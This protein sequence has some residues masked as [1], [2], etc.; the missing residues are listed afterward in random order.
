MLGS[1]SNPRVKDPFALQRI[2][3]AGDPTIDSMPVYLKGTIPI[4]SLDPSIAIYDVFRISTDDYAD[5]A[6]K[7]D[8]IQLYARVFD[9][10]GNFVTNMADPYKK[11]P[12]ETYFTY[13]EEKLGKHYRQRVEE[14]PEFTVREFGAGDSIAYSL[15]LTVDYSGSME[16]IKETIAEG[17]ELMADMKFPYD[18][19]SMSTFN[20]EYDQK[21]PFMVNS[22]SI[23]SLFRT[24]KYRNFGLFSAVRDAVANSVDSLSMTPSEDPRVLVVFSDGDD[25]YSTAKI[26]DIIEK[27]KKENINIFTIAFG[28]SE[29]ENLRYMAEYTGGK[30]YK[31]RSKEELLAIFKDIYMSLRYYYL[32]TYV[33][34]VFWGYHQVRTDLALKGRSDLLSGYAEYDTSEL[35]PWDDPNNTFERPIEF[36]FNK[37]DLKPESQPIIDEIVDAMMSRPIMRIEVRGHT[38]NVG[39]PEYN[40]DLSERRAAVVKNAIIEAGINQRRVRSRGFGYSMPLETNDTEEGRARN[41][42]TEFMV[43]AK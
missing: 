15:S 2:A 1:C 24:V 6:D 27:A 7:P 42:R 23:I 32:I 5:K 35:F 11:F 19:F 28:F 8:T 29:D 30:F 21:V 36:E 14:V 22:D 13:M 20:R 34:P 18:R 9:S 37:A 16:M 12:E 17:A 40:Q 41:R 33:P 10:L 25:N 39:T 31:A 4:D 26:G 43:I 38:D 3:A